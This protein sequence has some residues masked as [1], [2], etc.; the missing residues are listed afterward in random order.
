[1]Q[2]DAGRQSLSTIDQLLPSVRM[3]TPE[4][5]QAMFRAAGRTSLRRFSWRGCAFNEAGKVVSRPV[6]GSRTAAKVF[7]L[8]PLT[9]WRFVAAWD[10]L[11]GS[12]DHCTTLLRDAILNVGL[13][14]DP[15]DTTT[16]RDSVASEDL[17]SCAV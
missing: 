11:E 4:A 13:F 6:I 5:K 7:H 1:M 8:S 14:T 2:T 16:Q 17:V 3:L 15:G 9:V 10:R 12:D